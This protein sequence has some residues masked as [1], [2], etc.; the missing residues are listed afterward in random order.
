MG[1]VSLSEAEQRGV[2]RVC[3]QSSL[4]L[5]Q[6]GA[7]S[8]L[9][10]SVAR[11]LGLAL[12]V[13]AVEIALMSNG[14]TLATLC[15]ERSS[16]AVRRNLDRGIN[17]HVVTEVQ[18]ILLLAEAGGLKL[19]EVARRLNEIKPLRYN[20]WLVS[21]MIGLSCACFARIALVSRGID[22]DF[23]TPLLTFVASSVAMSLR[24][25]LATFQFNP[26]INFAAAAFVATS[27]AAQGV[28][29]GWVA[30]PKIAMSAC[31]LLFVPGFPLINA[32]SDM[33]K[34]FINT[35]VSRG[36]IALLLLL[37]SCAGIILAMT[38]W[39]TWTWL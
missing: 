14:I 17:M 6:H 29:Y 12:G 15:G 21:F 2:T 32:M 1:T 33:V 9:V 23:G 19:D 31:V 7:E 4:M 35:G 8:A 26:L 34:G 25:W 28:R 37:A 38:V 10:E 5:L 30:N 3:V 27:I 18:R 22:N 39:E 13:D 36:C 20:R 11:R 16:T 24:Q